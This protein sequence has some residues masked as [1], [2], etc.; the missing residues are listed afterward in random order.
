MGQSESDPMRPDGLKGSRTLV[1]SHLLEQC[2]LVGQ[3]VLVLVLE[4]LLLHLLPVCLQ[5]A[6][7]TFGLQTWW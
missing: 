4:A 1:G 6:I 7:G 5:L 3:L 2:G